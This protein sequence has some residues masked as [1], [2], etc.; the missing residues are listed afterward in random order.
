MPGLIL[1]LSAGASLCLPDEEPGDPLPVAMRLDEPA[2]RPARRRQE[3]P[4]ERPF[5]LDRSPGPGSETAGWSVS[6]AVELKFLSGRT[7]VREWDS[8]PEWLDL[9]GDLGFGEAPG[10]RLV[11][12]R[13]TRY[14]RTFLE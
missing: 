13:D 3:E 14:V 7:R 1:I 12:A 11:L 8:R 6:A 4:Q 10:L 5:R 2:R 9:G